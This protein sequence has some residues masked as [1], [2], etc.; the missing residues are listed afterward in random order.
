VALTGRSVQ[1]DPRVHAV[2]PDLADIRLAARVF[3]PHYAAPV[4][5]R[6]KGTTALRAERDAASAVIATLADGATFELLDLLGSDA[7]GVAP[8][9]QLV[10]YLAAD[11]LVEPTR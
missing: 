2:R 8:A 10:G 7:W 5:R 6:V 11:A 1:L 4:S 9:E 3:A